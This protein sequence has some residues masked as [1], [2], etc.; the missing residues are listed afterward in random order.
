MLV[1]GL[2]VRNAN[3]RQAEHVREV[4]DVNY[5]LLDANEKMLAELVGIKNALEKNGK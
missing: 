2:F 1:F 3:A 4:T 5:R